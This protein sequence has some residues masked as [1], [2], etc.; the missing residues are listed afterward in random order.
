MFDAVYNGIISV[1]EYFS[2]KP[3]YAHVCVGVCVGGRGGRYVHVYE[4][5][6]VSTLQRMKHC[7]VCFP[8]FLLVADVFGQG[9]ETDLVRADVPLILFP[10]FGSKKPQTPEMLAR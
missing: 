9:R 10:P 7:F 1:E 6:Y 4:E 3:A 5:I 8:L 2:Q